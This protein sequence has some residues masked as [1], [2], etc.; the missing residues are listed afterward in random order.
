MLRRFGFAGLSLAA[1]ALFFWQVWHPVLQFSSRTANEV[2]GWSLAVGLPWLA[3]LQAYR[4]GQR[5]A[6]VGAVTAGIPLSIWSLFIPVGVMIRNDWVSD[7]LA[8]MPWNGSAVRVNR[9]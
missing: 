1:T 9:S 3:D 8:E 4:I 5:W 6:K 2:F 7:R